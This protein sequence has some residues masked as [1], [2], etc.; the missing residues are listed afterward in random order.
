MGRACSSRLRRHRRLGLEGAVVQ[1]RAAPIRASVEGGAASATAAGLNSATSTA[2]SAAQAAARRLGARHL[3]LGLRRGRLRRRLR[4]DHGRVRRHQ[5]GAGDQRIGRAAGLEPA[6]GATHDDQRQQQADP[7]R[8][9]ALRSRLAQMRAANR[10]RGLL[11]GAGRARG[12]GHGICVDHHAQPA[13]QIRQRLRPL[14]RLHG[15]ALVDDA[16]ELLA[17]LGQAQ[18]GQG[19]VGSSTRRSGAGGGRR[20]VT[21]ECI[22]AHSPYTSV[23]GPR[24]H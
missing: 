23:Q 11:R 21:S 10:R 20:P 24:G 12:R 13:R 4:S 16:Q 6:K 17:V 3:R 1:E 8:L 22:T 15:Q 19:F 9:A 18:L 2:P 14:G 5:L 7:Y